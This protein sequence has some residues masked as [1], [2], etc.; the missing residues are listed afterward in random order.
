MSLLPLSS[1]DIEII[2]VGIS[3]FLAFTSHFYPF[4]SKVFLSGLKIPFD[5]SSFYRY[6][7]FDFYYVCVLCYTRGLGPEA[8]ENYKRYNKD[9]C[10][11]S[12]HLCRIE[13]RGGTNSECEYVLFREVDREVGF[14]YDMKHIDGRFVDVYRYHISDE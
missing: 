5:E 11:V 10:M 14:V 1:E 3:N 8:E 12:Q 13:K 2:E 6:D 7:S 4:V 9:L